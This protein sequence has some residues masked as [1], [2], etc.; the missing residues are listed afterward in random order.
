MSE[1]LIARLEEATEGSLVLDGMIY[2]AT[3]GLTFYK[4]D[5][6]GIV[7]REPEFQHIPANRVRP[8]SVSIDAALSLVPEPKWIDMGQN[9]GAGAWAVVTASNDPDEDDNAFDANG[10][11]LALALCILALKARQNDA[12]LR[13]PTSEA[14]S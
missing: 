7:V 13:Q 2:C 5:G 11:T 9:P 10:T 4:W 12:G 14:E 1:S 8:Y 6:A 3:R